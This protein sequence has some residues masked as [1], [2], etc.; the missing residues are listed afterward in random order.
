[1]I[2]LSIGGFEK[3]LECKV[4]MHKSRFSVS[5][6]FCTAI[7]VLLIDC[8]SCPGRRACIAVIK[9]SLAQWFLCIYT[10]IC[11]QRTRKQRQ[12]MISF[13]GWNNQ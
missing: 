2:F 12:E 4:T 6:F 11:A 5:P 8:L 1:M 10:E 7:I 13:S 3:C 9:L